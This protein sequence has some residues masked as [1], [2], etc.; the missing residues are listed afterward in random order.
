MDGQGNVRRGGAI[1][2]HAHGTVKRPPQ[3]PAMEPYGTPAAAA[4]RTQGPD[5]A[6]GGKNGELSRPVKKRQPDG[7]SWVQFPACPTSG[8]D[9][10]HYF[11]WPLLSDCLRAK[12]YDPPPPQGV[13][14]EVGGL[15][16]GW[17]GGWVSS[18]P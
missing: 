13:C 16:G 10:I 3:Q 17:V 6:R 7:A 2:P 15:K 14:V 5:V 1:G 11:L 18:S 12:V 4:I 9:I 8:D